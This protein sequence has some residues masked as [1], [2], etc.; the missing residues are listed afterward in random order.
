MARISKA[1][2]LSRVGGVGI[3][4]VGDKELRKT[5]KQLRWGV[6][7]EVVAP[8]G[9]Q[10][11]RPAKKK[12][13]AAT[14]IDDEFGKEGYRVLRRGSVEKRRK[15]AFYKAYD[16]EFKKSGDIFASIAGHDAAGQVS[17]TRLA[18]VKAVK[19]KS[20]T[21]RTRFA[22]AIAK[23]FYSRKDPYL[24]YHALI[25][26]FGGPKNQKHKGFFSRAWKSSSAAVQALLQVRVA[27]RLNTVTNRLRKHNKPV[28]KGEK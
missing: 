8:A 4:L 14:P 17:D 19:T 6:L 15:K 13:I 22:G 26:E 18:M 28:F 2:K 3:R 1:Q 24:A 12:V 9:K 11:L 23:I 25:N 16:K 5:L 7:N 10:A 20:V 27:K 21:P